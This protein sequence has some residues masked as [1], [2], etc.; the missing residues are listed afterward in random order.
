MTKHSD[1]DC[2]SCAAMTSSK[3]WGGESVDDEISSKCIQY[4]AKYCPFSG[5]F[6]RID[7]QYNNY[8]T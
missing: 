6:L 7:E 8:Y 4:S 5:K 3:P 2:R 1:D